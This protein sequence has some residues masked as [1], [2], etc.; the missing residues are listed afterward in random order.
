MEVQVKLYATLC[1]ARPGTR[2]GI[3]FA[4]TLP[5]GATLADLVAQLELP[6]DEIK[7][8]FVNGLFR[9]LDYALQPS[10]EVGIFPPIGGG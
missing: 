10:D 4:V 9:P 7:V 6:P 2:A 3:P 8:T 1:R 5:A